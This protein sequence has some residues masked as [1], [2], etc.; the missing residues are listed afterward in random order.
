MT[1]TRDRDRVQSIE[2]GVAVLRVFA[3][4]EGQLTMS[5]V[6]ARADLPRPVV[7]R[8]LLTFEHLGYARLHKG[9]WSLTPRILELGSGYFAASSL[10]EVAYPVLNDVVE[11]TNETCSLGVLEGTEV[12][13]V[14]RVEDQ[15]PMPGAIRIGMKLP[16]Y[17]TALGKALLAYATEEELA[18]FLAAADLVAITP[19]TVTDPAEFR[20]RLAL[21]REQGYDLSVEEYTPGR[22][23]AAAPIVLD[24]A[25]VGALAVSTTTSRETVESM[26]ET[27]VPVLVEAADSIGRTYRA[28]NPQ[29]YRSNGNWA[30]HSAV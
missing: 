8:I 22:L 15:R 24:G 3:G 14:A 28:A 10:P 26:V 29:F 13:H 19:N 1:D 18:E 2:R 4:R 17:A 21:V 20:E 25:A 23:S 11:R 16:A 9:L 6:A 7:R 27:I 30:D 5:D 12:I